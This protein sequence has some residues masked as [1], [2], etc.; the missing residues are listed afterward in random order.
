M[1]QAFESSWL[2]A[3]NVLR[4]QARLLAKLLEIRSDT[5]S[6]ERLAIVF[7]DGLLRAQC[8]KRA[9]GIDDFVSDFNLF[10][11]VDERFGKLG[12]VAVLFGGA[13]EIAG[14][15]RRLLSD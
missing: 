6:E 7:L 4:P 3:D 11:L 2:H 13:A 1:R 5:L 12:V 9:L 10:L 15:V 8:Q 14:K